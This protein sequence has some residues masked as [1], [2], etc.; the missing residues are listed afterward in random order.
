M[1]TIVQTLLSLSQRIDKLESSSEM[2][3]TTEQMNA[4]YWVKCATTSPPSLTLILRN[5]YIYV[6]A[7]Q[8]YVVEPDI[9]DFGTSGNCEVS[10]FGYQN[11][12]RAILLGVHTDGSLVSAESTEQATASLAETAGLAL[13]E[14]SAMYYDALPVV[15]VIV[16]NNGSALTTGSIMPIEASNRGGSYIWRKVRPWLHIHQSVHS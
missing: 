13:L 10:A 1:D 12:F 3:D 9:A 2:R 14:S 8:G 7:G 4:Y 15:I 16:R 6:S 11:Y 5:A